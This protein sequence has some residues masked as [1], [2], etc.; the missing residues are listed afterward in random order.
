MRRVLRHESGTSIA[1]IAFVFLM[2]ASPLAGSEAR[3]ESA[4]TITL[5]NQFS[6]PGALRNS[7]IWGWIDFNTN[8]EYVAIGKW[9][10]GGTT[11]HIVEVTDPLNPSIVAI[12]NGV[13]AFDLKTW[14]DYLYLCAA[15]GA[16]TGGADRVRLVPVRDA[17][18]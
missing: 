7:D 10:G 12:M 5:V 9:P 6:L 11:V 15:T 1:A 18:S 3:A 17:Q 13:P 2:L 8:R 14:G 4:P 16:A